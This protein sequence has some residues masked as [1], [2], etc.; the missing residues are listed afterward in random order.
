MV[1]GPA[2]RELEIGPV[3]RSKPVA[4]GDQEGMWRRHAFCWAF[5]NTRAA[6]M[7]E[8]T[9]QDGQ[10]NIALDWTWDHVP[11]CLEKEKEETIRSFW[12]GGSKSRFWGRRRV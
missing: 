8:E 1:H 7:Q 12:G 6:P 5:S 10:E 4:T 11:S 2:T 3:G 9:W